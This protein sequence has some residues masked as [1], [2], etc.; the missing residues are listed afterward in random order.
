MPGAPWWCGPGPV[1]RMAVKACPAVTCGWNRH[2][3]LWVV[4]HRSKAAGGWYISVNMLYSRDGSHWTRKG[5][6]VGVCGARGGAVWSQICRVLI[7]L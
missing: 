7:Q 2:V 1:G 4:T 6:P 5:F 3:E